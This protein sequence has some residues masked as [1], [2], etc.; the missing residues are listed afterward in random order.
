MARGCRADAYM[1]LEEYEK[2]KGDYKVAHDGDQQSQRW[3]EGF[4][5]AEAALKRAGMRDYY[6]I[7]GVPRT[8]SQREIKKSFRKLAQVRR[9]DGELPSKQRNIIQTSIVESWIKMPS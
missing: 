7:L 8:A 5:K 4:R 9:R 1:A 3:V 6:K 2:A